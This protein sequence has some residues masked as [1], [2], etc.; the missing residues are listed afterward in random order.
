MGDYTLLCDLEDAS[1]WVHSE[2]IAAIPL[3]TELLGFGSGDFA[4][5]ATAND[6]LSDPSGRWFRYA[7]TGPSKDVRVI[8]GCDRTLPEDLK[9]LPVWNK[10]T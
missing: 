9:H 7:L 8:V 2:K 10:V 6:V 3:N 5:G 4:D 1:L